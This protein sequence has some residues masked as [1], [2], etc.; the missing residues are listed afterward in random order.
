MHVQAVFRLVP[1][2]R[3]RPVDDSG[4]DFLAAVRRQAVQE[5]RVRA[6]RGHHRVVD[7]EGLSS[8][9]ACPW[10]RVWPIDTQVSVTTTSAPSTAADGDAHEIDAA[11]ARAG[12][13][14]DRLIGIIAVRHAEPDIEPQHRCRLDQRIGHVVAIAEIGPAAAGDRLSGALPRRS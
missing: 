4:G 1:D 3:V 14:D 11:A 8:P 7:L 10:Y 6:G 12:G 5:Q 13:R 2:Q 9:P